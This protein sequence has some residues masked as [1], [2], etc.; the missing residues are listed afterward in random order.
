[1]TILEQAA[2]IAPEPPIVTRTERVVRA[3]DQLQLVIELLNL[4]VDL[5]TNTTT[6]SSAQ[7]S[8]TVPSSA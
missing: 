8:A 5:G 7:G 2:P 4:D 1:V 6:S 3:D